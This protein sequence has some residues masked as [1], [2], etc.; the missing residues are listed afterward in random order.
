MNP[1]NNVYSAICVTNFDNTYHSYYHII[2]RLLL[3]MH[4]SVCFDR[5]ILK[6]SQ[7]CQNII[8]YQSRQGMMLMYVSNRQA[9]LIYLVRFWHIFLQTAD[10]LSCE[11]IKSA[12][13]NIFGHLVLFA[14]TKCL[15]K[16]LL[17]ISASEYMSRNVCVVLLQTTMLR[18]K[19]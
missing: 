15:W 9:L 3:H 19:F 11:F 6:F 12:V 4:L 2:C 16:L 18:H 5:S 8:R 7:L 13:S 14:G 17:F 1:E 10:R